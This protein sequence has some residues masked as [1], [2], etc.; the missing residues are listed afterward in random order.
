MGINCVFHHIFHPYCFHTSPPLLKHKWYISRVSRS[1]ERKAVRD[2]AWRKKTNHLT[3]SYVD[4]VARW[5][6]ISL[7]WQAAT[8]FVL[9][10]ALA[11]I[12]FIKI[13]E[14]RESVRRNSREL[15]QRQKRYLWGRC[16]EFM[17]RPPSFWTHLIDFAFARGK[18]WTRYSA[19]FLFP[20]QW[21]II[22]PP[23]TPLF[24]KSHILLQEDAQTMPP[25]MLLHH[26]RAWEA[27]RMFS[28]CE[29][30]WSVARAA[31]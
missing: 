3:R 4:Y 20:F 8:D 5:L 9:F 1:K 25:T 6:P 13:F 7:L 16:G 10:L 17:C 18:P 15:K 23:P 21:L 19:H 26:L 24:Q 12:Y 29:E 28:S 31:Y 22:C 27:Q 14:T 11:Q 30:L 2:V